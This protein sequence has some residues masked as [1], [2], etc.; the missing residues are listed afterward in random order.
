MV[1]SSVIQSLDKNKF[2]KQEGP[3]GQQKKKEKEKNEMSGGEV[4]LCVFN[5]ALPLSIYQGKW[6]AL[7]GHNDMQCL[8]QA[9]CLHMLL[10]ILLAS[11]MACSNEVHSVI[12]EA[13]NTLNCPQD[14]KNEEAA[15]E[16]WWTKR[17]IIKQIN[18]FIFVQIFWENW[19]NLIDLVIT[20]TLVNSDESQKICSALGKTVCH[21]L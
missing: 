7:M 20:N 10:L 18:Y 6:L 1:L 11:I 3:R 9:I 4:P 14:P 16:R 19:S 8:A 13:E 17:L 2:R 12:G 5:S 21:F 15:V